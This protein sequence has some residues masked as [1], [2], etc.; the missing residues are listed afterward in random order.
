M[1]HAKYSLGSGLAFREESDMKYLKAMAARGWMFDGF[2]RFKRYRFI[3]KEKTVI[4]FHLDYHVDPTDDYFKRFKEAGWEHV[5][6]SDDRHIF[7][8]EVGTEKITSDLTHKLTR[9]EEVRR[10]ILVNTASTGLFLVMALFLMWQNTVE[11]WNPVLTVLL[12]IAIIAFAI[13]G[14]LLTFY[15]L[16]VK[17]IKNEEKDK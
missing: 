2:G 12:I 5:A 4:D 9:Y 16:H 15:T 1:K 7:K 11:R 8:G 17:K 6:S 10:Q 3:R 13:N 14:L